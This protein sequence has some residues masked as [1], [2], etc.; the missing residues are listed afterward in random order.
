MALQ[1][2]PG[3]NVSEIDLTTIVPAVAT[4]AAGLAGQ[5]RW[6][7]VEERVLVTNEEEL[8]SN[9]QKPNANNAQDFFAAADF[10]SYAS[11]LYV[12]RAYASDALNATSEATTGSNT[13]GT[14]LL[15]KNEL[16]YEE[17]YE[18]GSGNSGVFAAKYAGALGNSLKISLCPG[19]DA[20]ESTLTGN[21]AV[22]AGGTTLTGNG[23]S[24][25]VELV[26]GDKIVLGGQTIKVASIASN[27]SLTLATSHTDGIT[28]NGT[29][30]ATPTR[31]WEYFDSVDRAP[32]TSPD[33]TTKGSSVD[34]L[35]A[36]VVDEDGL[37]TGVADQVLERFENIS[38][39]SDAKD[40]T[41][42][43]N[44]YKDV[45]NRQ[46]NYVWWLDH[47]S[48]SSNWGSAL[49]TATTFDTF[50]PH[51]RSMAGGVDG[52]DTAASEV[53][54]ASNYFKNE[55][56]ADIAFLIEARGDQTIATHM[57]NNIAEVRQDVIVTLSPRRSDVVD[58]NGSEADSVV[59]YR[60]LLPSS[61][62][63]VMG[64]AWKNRFDKYN[65]VYRYT[66]MSGDLA[67]VMA[68]TD[69]VRDPWF[70]PAGTDRGRI[71]NVRKLS[72]NPRKAER[73]TLYKNGVNP[74]VTFP[75]QGTLLFGDKTLLGRSSAFDRINVRRLFITIEEAIAAAAESSLFEFNDEF[76]RQQFVNLI[77]PYLR[78]VQARRGIVDFRVVAD[79]T[80]NTSDIID[81]NQ[82]VGDIYI[83]PNRSINFI[84][85]N[86]VAVRSG[87][88]FNEIVGQF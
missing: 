60:N 8:V 1:V 14:G 68:R 30:S 22:T 70:S 34:E 76:T 33:A 71:K 48:D 49:S 29:G 41:G 58:N 61:S 18:D 72:F 16:H 62:Y 65:D 50:A 13:A 26:V 21:V 69:Q 64:S 83:K 80:N 24:F 81:S 86:F 25:S 32:G 20:F 84:Q 37:W 87:V 44:Y 6:G 35:H 51:T 36:V 56:E 9:F 57:I 2:S 38:K 85:L 7:P 54:T 19:A 88:E 74:I 52:A 42:A 46:S 11:A 47:P 27:T 28:I 31:R 79:E 66:N 63:A 5:F 17:N 53:V 82:F 43:S 77:E 55:D 75:N 4:S 3:V 40:E 10:L 12:V 73:D 67:G 59:T 78:T 45:I 39:G 15:V 23:T